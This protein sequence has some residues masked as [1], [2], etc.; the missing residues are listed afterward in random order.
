MK[1]KKIDRIFLISVAILTFGGFFIFTSASLG[2][3]AQTK[4]PFGSVT[5]I[6]AG[7]LVL[8]LL[9]FYGFSKV[10]YKLWSKYSLY[11]FLGAL[12][13]NCL[14]FI[15]SL[16]VNHGG[17]G[18]WINLH[19]LTFQPSELLKIA[20]IIY[21]S[22]WLAHAKEKVATFKMGIF[23]YFIIIGI[24]AGLLLAQSDTFT[25]GVIIVTGAAM[26]IVSGAKWKHIIL[27]ALAGIIVIS[28]V[29][30]VRPYARQRVIT[31][32]NPAADPQ[33]AGYQIQQSLIAIGSGGITG[34]GYGQSVQKFGYLPQ[35][36]DDSIFAVQAEE[37]GFLGSVALIGVFLLFV[38]RCFK[39]AVRAPDQWSKLYVLGLSTLILVESY[40][41]IA[42]MLGIVPLSGKPLLFV[43]HGGTALII[44][45]AAVGVIANISKYQKKL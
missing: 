36:I 22:A 33:G 30:Y 31:F 26:L 24:L 16:T 29:A 7:C 43:S 23:P 2:L 8:G 11:I 37:F 35:P 5:I 42:A 17:A 1:S 4:T 40:T 12:A 28:T 18:R 34:R 20:F 19:F 38:F 27:I 25:L 15:P 3:L 41:N 32:L 21:F 39:I 14:L 10:P 9:L 45:L 13:V 6:Q 44:I